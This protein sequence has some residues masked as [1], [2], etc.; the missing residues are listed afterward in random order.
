MKVLLIYPDILFHR[1]DWTG[2]FYV[3]IGS[4]SAV[5]KKEGHET[6]L[7]H[8]TK[9]V[10]RSKFIKTV[11]KE[12]PDLIGFSATSPMFPLVRQYAS[13]LSGM[14]VPTICGGIHPTIAPEESIGVKGI[15]II[16]RGEGEAPLAELC[17]RIKKNEDIGN[18]PNLW[19]KCNDTIVKNPLRPLLD[20]LDSLPYPDRSIF[21]Y[22]TLFHERLGGAT[23]VASRGCPYNCTYCCNH[24]LRKIYGSQ[25]KPVRFRSVDNLV[26]EIRQ[27]IKDYPFVKSLVFDDDILFLKRTWSKEFA[28]KC[29]KQ[30]QLPLTCNA[31]PDV[32]DK[33]M[34]KLMKKAGCH[35]VKFGLESGNEYISNEVLN[36]HLTNESIK[37]AFALCKKT[38]LVA[39][40]FNMIGVPHDT[41]ATILDTI[42]LNAMIGV[43]KMQISIYQ[44]YQ[45]TRLADQCDEQ[46]Y[47]V[48]KDLESDWFSPMLELDTISSSQVLMFRDYFKV[49]VR[50]YQV[51]QKLPAGSSEFF[52]TLSDKI[53]SFDP[54]SYLL[55]SIYI[56]LNYLYRRMLALKMKARIAWRE[57]GRY[58]LKK[59]KSPGQN[60]HGKVRI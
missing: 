30:I 22:A 3:G 48:Q 4:L 50:F 52:I 47:I 39:E 58:A 37:N 34:V 56:P 13:W 26:G 7:F 55:N 38:G 18:I 54:S 57:S 33:T 45:G 43:D 12:A 42:K 40:S 24:L 25:H 6:S 16:C 53:L 5:L 21:S 46:N 23:F 41:P 19:T 2:Y 11:E 27:V 17:Q 32:T 60:K 15:D 49:L 29:G 35:H 1:E 8:V 14:A 31:R 59:Y 20:D 36:R 51:L 10:N 28:E 44:P 9:P